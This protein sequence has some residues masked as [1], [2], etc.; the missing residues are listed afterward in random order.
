MNLNTQ[1]SFI[2]LLNT[3][4]SFIRMKAFSIILGPS[5]L[6]E[7]GIFQG[8]LASF[9]IMGSFGMGTSSVPILF[10]MEKTKVSF[11]FGDI[12]KAVIVLCTLSFIVFYTFQSF[13]LNDLTANKSLI[14]FGVLFIAL[15]SQLNGFLVFFGKSRNLA[16][17]QLLSSV[18]TTLIGVYL[19]SITKNNTLIVA[20]IP[21]FLVLI[22]SLISINNK[23]NYKEV[24]TSKFKNLSKSFYKESFYLFISALTPS[25]LLLFLRIFENE[26]NGLASL[27][28]FQAMIVLS[29]AYSS[30]ILAS[31]PTSYFSRLGN[32]DNFN[33]I[34]LTQSKFQIKFIP[35]L[36]FLIFI[37]PM[38]PMI[39]FTEQFNFD[40]KNISFFV[41][42][43]ILRMFSLLAIYILIAKRKS[44]YILI[45]DFLCFILL[46]IFFLSEFKIFTFNPYFA[47]FLFY[48][49]SMIISIIVCLKFKYLLLKNVFK[50]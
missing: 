36:L 46:F 34:Y 50:T 15:S 48:L 43:D 35:F 26:Q 1:I 31:I 28:N 5:G 21:A 20:I 2:S 16:L 24:F 39:F 32:K 10:K 4:V 12:F 17:I 3:F 8:I 42:G 44:H 6:A 11:F 18:V 13:F 30:V 38:I 29:G 22:F 9:G 45:S 49:F 14:F 41:F 19:L 23:I 37:S 40:I 7:L 25:L 47:Y 27:G 33:D